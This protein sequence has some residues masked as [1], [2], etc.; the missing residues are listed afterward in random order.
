M[1]EQE[2]VTPAVDPAEA[3]DRERLEHIARELWGE[4]FT[5]ITKEWADGDRERYAVRNRGLVR[6][7]KS[8]EKRY[9]RDVLVVAE[10]GTYERRT[11]H[12]R[13][14]DVEIPDEGQET[15][16]VDDLLAD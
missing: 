16:T 7:D 3:T 8:D 13:R 11:E 1:P 15:G 4:R 2:V 10:D 14:E 5:I 12:V 9:K 6:D